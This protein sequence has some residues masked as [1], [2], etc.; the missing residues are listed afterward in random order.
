MKAIRTIGLL[1][2]IAAAF[3]GGYVYKAI[4]GAP[5]GAAGKSERKVLYWVDPMHPAYKSDKPGIAPDCGMKLEPV[6]ADGGAAVAP[7]GANRKVLYYRDPK[8]PN[9]KAQQPGLNP[10]TGSQLDPVYVNDISTMEVGTVQITPEKQQLIGVKYEQV[11]VGGGSRTIRAVGKVAID[12]TRIGHVHTKVEG[13]VDKV[14]VDFTGKL[15]EKGQALLTIYSPDML[16]SQRELLL[17]AKAKNIMQTSTLPG[18]YDQS[19]SLLQATRRR[20]ELWDLS[21]AQIDQ[22]LKTGEPIKNITLYSP[23]TGYITD[24]KAFPQV[25]VMPDTDLYTIVDLS[26]VWIMADVFEYEAPNIRVGQTARVSLQALP[27]RS[28]NARID[29]LQPQVDPM[30]RTLKVRLNMDNPGLMLK[31]DMYADIEFVVNIPSRL[32][33]PADAVLN[34][35][36]RKTVFVD[37]GNGYFEPRQ[38]KTGEREGDRIQILSGLSGGERVVTSGNFLIDSESQM[39]AAASGMGG[40]AGMPGMTN[41][42]AQPETPAS[43]PKAPPAKSDAKGMADMPG[44]GGKKQ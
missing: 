39:K 6:Y 42:P 33:V 43:Q 9:Y 15:V 2:V 36:E 30:T 18:A 26:H 4:K 5:S 24:R 16:A 38:V 44:M 28:F 13:W 40:M 14:F 32:T 41:K 27:G 34:A 10:E 7:A 29:F 8:D 20:L 31:P 37:R 17:A 12:E 22:V 11:E 35:G 19:E 1:V 25:K 21:E 3:A 23:M